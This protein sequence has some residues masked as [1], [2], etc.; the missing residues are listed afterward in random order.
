MIDKAAEWLRDQACYY[1]HWEWNGDTC[2][3]EIVVDTEKMVEDFRE[4][5]K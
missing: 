5:M 3:N 4:A 2:E 1:S